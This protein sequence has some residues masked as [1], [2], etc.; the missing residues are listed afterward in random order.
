MFEISWCIEILIIGFKIVDMGEPYRTFKV[1]KTF[2][3]LEA[4]AYI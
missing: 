1:Y 3:I 2:F 4:I